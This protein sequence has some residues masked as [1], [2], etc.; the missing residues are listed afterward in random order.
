MSNPA[1]VVTRAEADRAIA[2]RHL[3]FVPVHLFSVLLA[4]CMMATL[5]GTAAMNPDSTAQPEKKIVCSGKGDPEVV[6]RDAD[7]SEDAGL[8]GIEYKENGTIVK[9]Y[10]LRQRHF[11]H[12]IERAINGGAIE[13]VLI[14]SWAIMNVFLVCKTL[15]LMYGAVA[16]VY[17]RRLLRKGIPEEAIASGYQ[18][19]PGIAVYV[20]GFW[21]V[22]FSMFWAVGLSRFAAVVTA[23]PWSQDPISL[24]NDL[25]RIP[26]LLIVLQIFIFAFPVMFWFL[27][28]DAED[29][30]PQGPAFKGKIG[31]RK[32]GPRG[33]QTP[34]PYV[35]G[36][37]L[38]GR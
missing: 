21:L 15:Q 24:L 13:V 36:L 20:F 34:K 6:C 32:R 16:T 10:D 30:F 33:P 27:T 1:R 5:I 3:Y 14:L 31:W 18:G 12:A 17:A 35:T 25:I 28:N 8:I 11:E 23:V 4:I 9:T 37:N 19:R 22:F 29:Y 26:E 38:T 2:W 7:L